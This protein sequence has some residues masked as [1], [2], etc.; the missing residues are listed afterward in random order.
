MK[1]FF[2]WKDLFDFSN[3]TKDSKFFDETNQKVIG[4]MK[5]ELGEVT[6][7][8]FIGSKSKI[9]SVKKMMVKNIIQEKKWVLQLSLINSKMSYLLKKLLDTK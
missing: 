4:K 6:V 3:Y 2:Q 1:S 5:D 7:A 9:Y 8:D